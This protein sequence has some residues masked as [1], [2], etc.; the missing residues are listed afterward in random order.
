[1]V[2]TCRN[3]GRLIER[4]GHYW[5]HDTEDGAFKCGDP[6]PMTEKDLDVGVVGR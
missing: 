5:W 4:I 6:E 2:A 1:M 3:C